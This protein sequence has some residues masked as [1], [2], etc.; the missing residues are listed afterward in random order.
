[1]ESQKQLK[2]FFQAVYFSSILTDISTI[3][4]RS[5]CLNITILPVYYIFL[6]LF[7][8]ITKRNRDQ[9]LHGF[10]DKTG[11]QRKRIGKL[12]IIRHQEGNGLASL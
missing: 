6:R 11:L 4:S 2:T 5:P 7:S 9:T 1:M 8:A 3:I 10:G 12:Q